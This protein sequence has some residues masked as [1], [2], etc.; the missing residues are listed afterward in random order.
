MYNNP[1]LYN[2]RD[3]IDMAFN[4]DSVDL[5]VLQTLLKLIISQLNLDNIKIEFQGCDFERSPRHV[6]DFLEICEIMKDNQKILTVKNTLNEP[7]EPYKIDPV[8]NSIPSNDQLMDV[9]SH[10]ADNPIPDMIQLLDI[11]KRV[12]ALEFTAH[13]LSSMIDSLLKLDGSSSNANKNQASGIKKCNKKLPTPLGTLGSKKGEKL[14]EFPCIS[15]FAPCPIKQTESNNL[16]HSDIQQFECEI[17]NQIDSVNNIVSENFF[18]LQHQMCD[19]QKKFSVVEEEITD[20]MFAC[21]INDQ[22]LEETMT[23]IVDFN[24]NIFCFKSDIKTLQKEESEMRNKIE[25][26]EQQIVALEL[27]KAEKEVMERELNLKATVIELEKMIPRSEFTPLWE[28]FNNRI[29][30]NRFNQE[31]H[32]ETIKIILKQFRTELCDKL[33][34]DELEKFKSLVTTLFDTFVSN[35]RCLLLGMNKDAV[36]IAG[37]RSK[38]GTLGCLTCQSE[39]VMHQ[40]TETIPRLDSVATKF[41]VDVNKYPVTHARNWQRF[42]GG[43]KTIT[44]P[45]ERVLIKGNFS[46]EQ[47]SNFLNFPN[48]QPCFIISTDNL[49]YKA[50]PIKCLQNLKYRKTE[51]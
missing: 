27:N 34:K 43:E 30:Q 12:E 18:Y 10:K 2:F 49:I 37:V 8:Y 11:T 31:R 16:N 3:L 21:E 33:E 22:K 26:M 32:Q 9:I 5:K 20:L 46:T 14:Q 47:E 23:E 7:E 41:K 1:K 4:Q 38:P 13:K 51:T 36:G 24:S 39:M 40:T 17:K 6:T 45:T 19:M 48:S 15:S 28:D 35:L 29:E 44:K 42:C 50:D 25:I